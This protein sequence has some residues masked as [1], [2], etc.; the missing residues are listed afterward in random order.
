MPAYLGLD[1]GSNSVGS[2][3]VDTD[4]QDVHLA[5]SV[6]PAGVDEQEDKR[7]A[8]KNQARRQTRS[9]RRTISRRACRKRK[10]A[11][12]L[13]ERHLLPADPAELQK[14][15]DLN[16]WHLRRKALSEPLSRFEFGRVVMH[17]A[18]RRGAV[19]VIT[20][21]D[22]PDEG[23][24]KEGM[25][26]LAKELE[27]A[28]PQTTVGQFIADRMDQSR[29]PIQRTPD[30]ECSRGTRRRRKRQ[31][32]RWAERGEKPPEPHYL[33]PIRNRQYRMPE[34]QYLFAGRESIR[35]DFHRIVEVQRSFQ[36]SELSAI[37]TDELVR[38]LDDP[39]QTDTWRH[40]GL[41]FGQRRTYW[42]T[43]TLGRCVLE[44]TDRCVP[45]ADRHASYFRVI[46][47]VN[48]IRIQK[49]G[50]D[51]RPLTAAER[52]QVIRLLR[53]PLFK[54]RK[55]N[56]E[57]KSSASV[58]DV[59]E[60]LGI[61]ARDKGVRLNIEADEERKP[62]TDW[63]HC[64]IVHGAIGLDIWSRWEEAE[65]READL[66]KPQRSPE[67]QRPEAVNRAILKFDPDEPADEKRLH[68]LATLRCGLDSA[69]AERLIAAWK[70]R[71]KLEERLNLSR[72]AI[73]N[74]LPDMEQFDDQNKRWPTQQAARKAYAKVL[75][76]R[77][78][79]T[80][81][82]AD[83]IAAQRYDTAA[84]GLTA[85]ARYYMCLEKHQIK[86]NGE[87]V[88]DGE[89]RPLALPPPAPKLSNPV[90]R[91]AIHEVRRHILAYLRKFRRTPDRVVIE[92]ART[93][94]QSRVVRDEQLALIR[95][96]EA[97][98]KKIIAEHSLSGKS[99]NQ[100][101][102]A[103]ARVL[104]SKQ[105]REICPYCGKAGLTP[106]LAA[107]GEG[108]QLD[109][110]IP[111]SRGG[112]DGLSNRL[113]VHAH[114]NQG[115]LK[116]TPK[117]WLGDRFESDLV[118]RLEDFKKAFRT[119]QAAKSRPKKPNA[120]KRKR[121]PPLGP[122]GY[123][124]LREYARKWQNFTRTVRPEDEFRNSQLTDT[125][126]AA[127]QVAAYLADAL[128]DGR[129]LPERGDGQA[130][131][132]IFFTV[133][134]FTL[135]LRKDWQLFETLKPPRRDGRHGELTA[136]D[137]SKLAEK[138]RGDHREH[139]IDAV[140]IALT[141]TDIK[142]RLASEAAEA[143]EFYDE[144][145]H[146]PQSKDK[147]HCRKCLD[148]RAKNGR[149]PGKGHIP[150]DPEWGT[151]PRFRAQVLRMVYPRFDSSEHASGRR[152]QPG[153]P[154]LIIVSH[155]PVKR[156]L[157]GHLHKQ[158][159]YG[160]VFDQNG[161][162]IE[163]RTSIRQPI[164]ESPQSHL[165]PKHVRLPCPETR[166]QAVKRI[167]DE[168]RKDGMKAR[169]AK[170]R[171][172]EIVA[173]PTFKL[174][175]VDPPPGKSGIVRDLALRMV[176][177]KSLED[178][179]LKPDDFAPKELKAVLDRDG[180]LCQPSGVPIKSVVLL[181]A[182]N[183]P[184][185]FY[186]RNRKAPDG[187]TEED[188]DPRR[189]EREVRIYDSQNN[190]H[191]EIRENARG[192]WTGKVIPAH[193]AASRLRARLRALG[194]L[195]KPFRH[196]RRKLPKRLGLGLSEEARRELRSNKSRANLA[197]WKR[198]MRDLK[199]ERA[200]VIAEHPI[201]DRSG[202]DQGRFLLSLAEGE[203]IYARR[204]DRPDEPAEYYVVCKLD[205]SGNSSRIHFAPHWDARKASEQDRWDVTPGDLKDCGPEPGKPPQKVR[206][207]PLGNVVVLQND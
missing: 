50:H 112:E 166:E 174:R 76:E 7:G 129:G 71:P 170:Q 158:T 203:M 132:R 14:L 145:R 160:P 40:Q 102:E 15:F 133:G 108:L 120:Q 147:E 22:D 151:V 88:R 82:Q 93:T 78:E 85:R 140:A 36:H 178:R 206:V 190:H 86:Q 44:P 126:Y 114:C 141:A 67:A 105:Q 183:D 121:K 103:V 45:I 48:N 195:E 58:T 135:M 182:N 53:G 12:F 123:F 64:E 202:N 61:K 117:E 74:L 2:A 13:I 66:P 150:I 142:Q 63:F 196:L 94:K 87:V 19:G 207:G 6:F 204:K 52:E 23:K 134:K 91:K 157:V 169:D 56:L 192:E 70:Q 194:A 118:P 60:A 205:K 8:P 49:R 113:L 27:Q 171:A 131:Q 201:V 62:N 5:A 179:G 152:D 185:V 162:R 80:G 163:N 101:R 72:R 198:K 57:P 18:Q 154:D 47:T 92:M 35:E 104:L 65:R 197:E 81:N 186:R 167:T 33:A 68:E 39:T 119:V 159:L 146:W 38:Q 96:R 90:V 191:V 177:R 199:P 31:A 77:F 83:R 100:Q 173:G 30:K 184:V 34:D 115:K 161:N 139:A 144:H 89:G 26:R 164:Y 111:K 176:L 41:L 188:E 79:Q 168:L 149:W 156:R 84:P 28:G 109:H 10:L 4:G 181:W 106:R 137:E 153:G 1:I 32:K 75:Q 9:Q 21:P 124:T 73:L 11:R 130:K 59:K 69:A 25:D 17:L 143:A 42:D 99:L 193:Q 180:P 138:N 54:K 43:G 20:D 122:D 29:Q 116:K 98:K 3:W 97:E 51:E 37:L 16:P 24:V 155:R 136:E 55:G 107:E 95:G 165:T 128:F 148:Y 200:R 187:Q 125:A 127:R 175:A 46:E 189:R 110:I 172:L